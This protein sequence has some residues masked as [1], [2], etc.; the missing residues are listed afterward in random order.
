MPNE[1]GTTYKAQV[2]NRINQLVIE[3]S[4]AWD[5]ADPANV[6]NKFTSRATLILGPDR[7][8]QGRDS[9]RAEFERSLR[10]MHGVIFTIDSFD[11]AGEL[12]FVRGTVTYEWIPPEGATRTETGVYAMSLRLQRGDKW[13]ITSHTIGGAV[14]IPPP[15][16]GSRTSPVAPSR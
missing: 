5:G 11:M 12:A 4:H 16:G 1:W 7:V 15:A 6:A 13:L 9:I 3:L 14:T 10:R 8:V 2:Q